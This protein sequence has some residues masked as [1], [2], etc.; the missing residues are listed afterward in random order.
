MFKSGLDMMAFWDTIGNG[1]YMLIGERMQID[2]VT[3]SN[4]EELIDKNLLTM[5]EPKKI[6]HK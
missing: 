6:K 2:N 1:E 5:V 4:T 3:T